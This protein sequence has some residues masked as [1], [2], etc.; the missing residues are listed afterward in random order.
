[1][2]DATHNFSLVDVSKTNGR[3]TKSVKPSLGLHCL[4]KKAINEYA[5]KSVNKF[6]RNKVGHTTWFLL[7][8]PRQ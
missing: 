8:K 1:M 2:T 7:I 5:L 6:I 3:V 4:L